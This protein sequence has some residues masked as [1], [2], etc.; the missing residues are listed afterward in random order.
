MVS[1]L[2]VASGNSI[3]KIMH[4]RPYYC[5]TVPK[6]LFSQGILRKLMELNCPEVKI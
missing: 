1:G 4:Q 2:V 3:L 5:E 6:K